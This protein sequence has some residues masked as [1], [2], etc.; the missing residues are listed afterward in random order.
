MFPYCSIQFGPLVLRRD[1]LLYLL[2][3]LPAPS[4]TCLYYF[5][6]YVLRVTYFR[7][8]FS[9]SRPRVPG[10]RPA[11]EARAGVRASLDGAACLSRSRTQANLYRVRILSFSVFLLLDFYSR[12]WLVSSII[13]HRSLLNSYFQD[14]FDVTLVCAYVDFG[15][16]ELLF[17]FRTPA[18]CGTVP[19][20]RLTPLTTLSP[21]T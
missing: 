15:F 4:S 21:G 19:L 1:F 18:T 16:V 11:N 2:P 6:C 12:L 8:L 14:S 7:V 13:N 3:S 20:C 17:L 9:F 5:L 10:R